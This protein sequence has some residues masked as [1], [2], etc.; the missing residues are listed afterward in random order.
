MSFYPTSNAIRLV[1]NGSNDYDDSDAEPE[2]DPLWDNSL[3]L[4]EEPQ[5]SETPQDTT[6]EESTRQGSFS[7]E[8]HEVRFGRTEME[9]CLCSLPTKQLGA[10]ATR[11]SGIKCAIEEM[12]DMRNAV[13]HFR[14]NTAHTPPD[15]DKLLKYAQCLAVE[16][17]YEPRALKIR[18]LRDA[19]RQRA[20]ELREI[21]VLVPFG[22][23]AS[24]PAEVEGPPGVAL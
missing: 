10:R 22:R 20:E 1:Y 8:P 12:A 14:G 2:M 13:C 18:G 24:L 17:R 7:E 21:E 16:L 5:T 6:L 4:P 19:L 23:F 3:P 9:S 15:I 11:A